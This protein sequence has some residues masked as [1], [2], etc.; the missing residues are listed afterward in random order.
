MTVTRRS[1]WSKKMVYVIL[2]DKRIEY[3]HGR[4]RVIYI[5]TTKR[6]SRRPATNAADKAMKAFN[7]LRGVKNIHVRILTCQARQSVKTW[8]ELESALLVTFKYLYG[9]L[10]QFN[11]KRGSY[12]FLPRAV[13]ECVSHGSAKWCRAEWRYAPLFGIGD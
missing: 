11:Y 3:P 9:R 13:A 2:A 10:P 6:G 12:R 5:G 4:S 7:E 1:L 8:E